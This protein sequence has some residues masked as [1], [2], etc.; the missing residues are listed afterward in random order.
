MLLI[1]SK[2]GDPCVGACVSG[3][4]RSTDR[5]VTV[6]CKNKHMH[7]PTKIQKRRDSAMSPTM[8]GHSSV[9]MPQLQPQRGSLPGNMQHPHTTSISMYSHGNYAYN[10]S[11]H[12]SKI[13]VVSVI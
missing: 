2:L 12:C 3:F 4:F 11:N 13:G 6:Q 7:N 9:K 10:V 8:Q 5:C 1:K